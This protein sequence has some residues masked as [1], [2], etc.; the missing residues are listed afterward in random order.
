M[1]RIW[2]RLDANWIDRFELSRSGDGW[3]LAGE[4]ISGGGSEWFP[5]PFTA[6][7]RIDVDPT[8]QTRSA[9]LAVD[10]EG[11]V[12]EMS[13]ARSEAGLWSSPSSKITVGLRT[14]DVDLYLT[15]ATNSL[16]IR[17]LDIP[18]GEHRDIVA[19]LVAPD[20]VTGKWS[21]EPSTQ[22]YHRTAPNTYRF[23]SFDETGVENFIADLVIDDDGIILTY[24]DH[25]ATV[26]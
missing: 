12:L 15:P 17:R 14:T 20:D 2:R 9:S 19:M 11:D 23:T 7:Y 10:V 4:I 5:R 16:P 18:I 26:E 1:N 25:W 3:L 13:L 21:V 8:W 22:R 24:G 6:N